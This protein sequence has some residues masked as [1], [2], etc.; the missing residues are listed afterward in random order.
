MARTLYN[1]WCAFWFVGI[2]LALAPAC[3]LAARWAWG[4]RWAA[5][6]YHW[7]GKAFFWVAG[8]RVQT[9]YEG[10]RPPTG[11]VIFCPN[12]SS[13]IDVPVLTQAISRFFVFIGKSS[14]GRVPIFGYVFRKVHIGVDRDSLRSRY[15]VMQQAAAALAQGK[16][17]V[18]FP[19]GGF[20]SPQPGQLGAFK[21]G[22]FKLAAATGRPIVPVSLP[23]NLL[24]LP[25]Q[26]PLRL[27]RQRA[28]VIFHA[29]VWVTDPETA[30]Q[31]VH[32]T[33]AQTLARHWPGL[34]N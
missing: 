34:G 28:K 14:L 8:I 29:P 24:I 7:W 6:F 9:E 11:P 2:Y 33:I 4:H 23:Y 26:M 22:A 21:E 18:L 27:H 25:D 3:L 5:R 12:H 16:S 20:G 17:L 15:A 31:E 30:R 10:P 32:R 13:Y 1:F 19:E